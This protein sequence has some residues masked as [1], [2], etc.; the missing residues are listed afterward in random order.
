MGSSKR[1]YR[2]SSSSSN[3][4]RDSGMKRYNREDRKRSRKSRKDYS[5]ERR[6]RST[7]CDCPRCVSKSRSP[8]HHRRIRFY[9]TRDNPYKSK[10]LGVFGLSQA[11]NEARLMEI[12]SPF[13]A[14]EHVTLI[15]DAKTGNSRGFGFIYYSKIHE[16]TEARKEING[17][18]IDGRRIRV[19][20]SITKRAHTPTPGLNIISFLFQIIDNLIFYRNLYGA[21]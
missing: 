6:S 18:T 20:F 14:V 10:V 19:D 1:K 7:I 17:N 15:Y 8:S 5:P 11:T 3:S 21:S 16:A 2:S 9:G 13:G 12:F 4:S